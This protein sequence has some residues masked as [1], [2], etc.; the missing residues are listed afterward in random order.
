MSGGKPVAVQGTDLPL[1]GMEIDVAAAAE[2]IRSIGREGDGM[3]QVDEFLGG[4]GLG[5]VA[6]QL[7]DLRLSV[8]PS[9]NWSLLLAVRA[10]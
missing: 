5:A 1:W 8:P 6:E 10:S 2:D 7:K 4:V 9:P 3:K